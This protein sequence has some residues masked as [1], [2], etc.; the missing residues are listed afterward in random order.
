[1]AETFRLTLVR[2]ISFDIFFN[3]VGN[4]CETDLK[5]TEL[6]SN[7]A[8]QLFIT[9][10]NKAY[11]RL[12]LPNKDDSYKITQLILRACFESASYVSRASMSRIIEI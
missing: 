9:S 4:K 11:Y 7:S 1:M 10:G 8:V 6:S 12:Y 2:Q 3:A 5:P